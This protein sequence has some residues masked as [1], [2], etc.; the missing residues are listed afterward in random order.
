ML[1]LL[2]STLLGNIGTLNTYYKYGTYNWNG[3]GIFKTVS[4]KSHH[5]VNPNCKMYTVCIVTLYVTQADV[6]YVEITLKISKT[7]LIIK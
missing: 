1:S 6:M 7:E 3:D 5:I 2:L 4:R